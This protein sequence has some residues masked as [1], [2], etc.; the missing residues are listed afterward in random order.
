[1]V[2]DDQFRRKCFN[3][4]VRYFVVLVEIMVYIEHAFGTDGAAGE[5]SDQFTMRTLGIWF[6]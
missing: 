1:M 2:Y 5:R 4:N 6:P 3:L